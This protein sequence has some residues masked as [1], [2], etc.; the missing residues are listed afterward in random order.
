MRKKIRDLIFGSRLLR[1]FAFPIRIRDIFIFNLRNI[2]VSLKWLF[3]SSEFTNY[4][5]DITL[6]NREYLVAFISYITK[7]DFNYVNSIFKEIENDADFKKYLDSQIEH[8]D[9]KYELPK[10]VFLGRRIGWYVLVRILRP[11]I[12]VETGTDKGLG[13]LL[14]AQ[15]L[16][17][18]G[19]G[20][21]YSLDIDLYSGALV[22]QKHWKNIE[23]LKGDSLENLKKIEQVNMFIHDSD[24]SEVHEMSEFETIQKSLSK[25]AIVISDNSQFTGALLEWSKRN[26]RRF[27]FFK[28]ESKNHWYPGDGIGVSQSQD[29]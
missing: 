8:L 12:V 7:N 29:F 2:F 1:I 5:Y 3:K 4:N 6:L 26:N 11:N 14:I 23:L 28:E 15:A 20:K 19:Y 13:T 17:K 9:R 24:H 10:Q 18:N 21:V 16:K 27:I 25:D 22:D